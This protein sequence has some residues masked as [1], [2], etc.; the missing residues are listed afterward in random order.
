MTWRGLKPLSQEIT[1]TY[2]R[3]VKLTQTAFR[4]IASQ[5]QRDPKLPKWSLVIPR[6][7]G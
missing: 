5:I 7:S 3:G 1:T 4:A 6:P 2:E